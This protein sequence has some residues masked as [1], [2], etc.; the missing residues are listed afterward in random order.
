MLTS[1]IE[2]SKIFYTVSVALTYYYLTQHWPNLAEDYRN[3][4]LVLMGLYTLS[5][6]APMSSVFC[7]YCSRY[8]VARFIHLC[9]IWGMTY[10]MLN[11]DH[12]LSSILFAIQT[13]FYFFITLNNRLSYEQLKIIQSKRSYITFFILS[14]CFAGALLLDQRMLPIA[15]LVLPIFVV[16]WEELQN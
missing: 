6:V 14:L 9:A 3:K 13:L 7:I 12:E 10:F 4:P 1:K 15:L 5:Y 8:I 11:T 16:P 2:Y